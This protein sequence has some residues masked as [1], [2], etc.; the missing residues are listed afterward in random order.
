MDSSVATCLS[1]NHSP[2]DL[3]GSLGLRPAQ[4]LPVISPID[5]AGMP[6]PLVGIGDK[7]RPRLAVDQTA[8]PGKQERAGVRR[9]AGQDN[10]PRQAQNALP[11]F[12]KG[13]L[14]SRS[15]R[16]YPPCNA[17]ALFVENIASSKQAMQIGCGVATALRVVMRGHNAPRK[18][19][20][21]RADFPIGAAKAVIWW[22]GSQRYNSPKNVRPAQSP[23][24]ATRPS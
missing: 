21:D 1:G 9:H 8:R 10:Q 13:R 3:I 20:A 12:W 2:V 6:A 14:S 4:V 22:H 17:L 19:V 23:G 11:S 18:V 7:A 24:S 16:R 15:S 5:R